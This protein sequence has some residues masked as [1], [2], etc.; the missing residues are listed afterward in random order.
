M[1]HSEFGGR[2]RPR[3]RHDDVDRRHRRRLQRPRHARRRHDRRLDLR[4]R[5]GRQPRRRA[6]AQLH[7]HRAELGRH[8]RHRLGDGQPPGRPARRGEHEP[9]R[10]Q[11]ACARARRRATRSPT[12]S[13]TRVAA[14]NEHR[15]RLHR[16]AVAAS[17]RRSRSAR[18]TNTDARASLQQL[19]HLRRL[20]RAGLDITSAGTSP[21]PPPTTISGTSMATPHV[22]GV[23]ALYL[24]GHP[25]ATPP[26][27]RDA[28]F[29]QTTKGIVTDGRT[30]TT[31]CSSR[32][33]SGERVEVG[34]APASPRWALSRGKSPA[35]SRSRRERWA[36]AL[37]TSTP[38]LL[39]ISLPASNEPL[40]AFVSHLRCC[41]RACRF[42]S[43]RPSTGRHCDSDRPRNR[44]RSGRSLRST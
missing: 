14:G 33:S 42:G 22:A 28:L 9:R 40:G 38:A 11:S 21:T 26:Q 3:R 12:A 19:R 24:Q 16:L 4:R 10:R 13:P 29:N 5:Q 2:A 8:R 17:P 35:L 34:T 43:A 18:R 37:T 6:R 15:G 7:R 25:T 44:P 1:T 39:A 31:T 30:R 20:L 23:A 36:V 27:V 41:Q 32:T